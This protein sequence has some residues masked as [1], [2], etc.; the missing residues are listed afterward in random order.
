MCASSMSWYVPCLTC[1]RVG[2]LNSISPH[3]PACTERATALSSFLFPCCGCLIG[4]SARAFSLTV[5]AKAPP[6][7]ASVLH[8]AEMRC[9]VCCVEMLGVRTW[10]LWFRFLC[11][12]L[13]HTRNGQRQSH[14]PHARP[15]QSHAVVHQRSIESRHR[16]CRGRHRPD[17]RLLRPERDG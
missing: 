5:S 11:A 9:A 3:R 17:C 16:G 14:F 2:A 15:A 7:R 6:H 1:V 12:V 8:C 4:R 13:M 10:V